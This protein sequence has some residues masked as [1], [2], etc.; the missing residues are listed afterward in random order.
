[1]SKLEEYRRLADSLFTMAKTNPDPYVCEAFKAIDD[2]LARLEV[3]RD[4]FK[5]MREHTPDVTGDSIETFD[6]AKEAL[7]K[8]DE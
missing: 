5:K 6:L 1:M 4:A 7:R 3:A 2:L 8:I